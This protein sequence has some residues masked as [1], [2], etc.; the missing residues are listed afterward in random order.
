MR[1]QAAPAA[2]VEPAG[3][4][5]PVGG[6]ADFAA[7]LEAQALPPLLRGRTTTLQVLGLH[8]N[9]LRARRNPLGQA[10]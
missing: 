8:R 6:A 2:P 10:R 7:H 5:G 1:Q 3:P 4:A 9:R